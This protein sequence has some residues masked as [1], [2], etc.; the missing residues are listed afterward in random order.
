MPLHSL[1]ILNIDGLRAD[2]F[3]YCL[4][5][6]TTPNLCTLFSHQS[7]LPD[8]ISA[9]PS[10]TFT[11]QGS[12]ISGVHPDEHRIVGNQ[13]FDRFGRA[14]RGEARHY[15]LDVGDT[16]SYDDAVAVFLGKEGLADRLMPVHLPTIFESV[17]A[18]GWRSVAIHLMY[19]RG[20]TLWL[21]PTVLELARFKMGGSRIGLTPAAF[22]SQ[23]VVRLQTALRQIHKPELVYLYFMGLDMTSHRKGPEA[24]REYLE[25]VIDPAVGHLRELLVH[26]G[27]GPNTGFMIVSDHGQI[28]VPNDEIHALRLGSPLS[29]PHRKWFDT[30]ASLGRPI[31]R[32]GSSEDS[33]NLVCAPNGGLCHLYLRQRDK[34]WESPP[35]FLN[36]VIATARKLGGCGDPTQAPPLDQE[37][38]AAI[39]VRDTEHQGHYAPFQA[40]GPEG[41]IIPLEIF[42]NDPRFA[43]FIAPSERLK[44]LA[45]PES[46]DIVVIANTEAGY[47]FGN[48]LKGMHGGLLREESQ[49]AFAISAPF[50]PPAEW[51]FCERDLNAELLSQRLTDGRSWQSLSDIAGLVRTISAQFTPNHPTL[52]EK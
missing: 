22:D 30:I 6:R 34:P 8:L 31:H 10:T 32:W 16:L 5:S 18:R 3:R 35:L 29:K 36:E 27:Y 24:Q 15:G 12:I 2:T 33:T 47:Y 1:I 42:F 23:V 43:N 28:A 45:T 25:K 49:C 11:C 51:L 13:Y 46:G 17:A 7:V 41:Q 21:K 44:R 9:A 20:A 26:H 37:T 4:E 48:P 38:I 40:L 39:L 50:L 14:H 19:G 52:A